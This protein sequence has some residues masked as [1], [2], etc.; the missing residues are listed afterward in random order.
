MTVHSSNSYLRK[1]NQNILLC[2]LF[3]G[4]RMMAVRS[5]G[6]EVSDYSAISYEAYRLC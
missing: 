4:G 2:V 6:E 1:S 5:S 3:S